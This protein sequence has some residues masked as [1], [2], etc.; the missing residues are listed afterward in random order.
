MLP[1]STNWL[2]PCSPN[3]RLGKKSITMHVQ[4]KPVKIKVDI[5][6]EV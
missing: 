6:S 2:D 5:F 1:M 3:L 4:I